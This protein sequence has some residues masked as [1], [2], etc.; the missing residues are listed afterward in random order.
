MAAGES[1]GS[2][3]EHHLHLHALRW[4]LPGSGLQG[5]ALEMDVGLR[6]MAASLSLSQC[7]V[8][9]FL[10]SSGS[11]LRKNLPETYNKTQRSQYVLFMPF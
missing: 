9:H 4:R 10:L 2:V 3:E 8:L 1:L 7:H 11:L 5:G 6:E